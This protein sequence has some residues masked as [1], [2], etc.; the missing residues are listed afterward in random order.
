MDRAKVVLEEAYRQSPTN[1]IVQ[2]LFT[3]S[4][5]QV[6]SALAASL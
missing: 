2:R 3:Q 5:G 4:G 1:P 6:S